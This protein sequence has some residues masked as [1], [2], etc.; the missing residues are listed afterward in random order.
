MLERIIAAIAVALVEWLAKR[1]EDS[2][3]ATD[4]TDDSELLRRAGN[5]IRERMRPKGRSGT[6]KQPDQAGR[7][8]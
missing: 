6:G 3:K 2:G 5:R 1:A 8:D 7:A 4:A